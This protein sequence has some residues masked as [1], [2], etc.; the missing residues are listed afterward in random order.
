M[1]GLDPSRLTEAQREVLA[2]AL[3]MYERAMSARLLR[4]TSDRVRDNAHWRRHV[5]R[6]LMREIED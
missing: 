5:A 1:N 6:E 3:A 4:A 2:T